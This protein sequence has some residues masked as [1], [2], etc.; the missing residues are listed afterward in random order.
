MRPAVLA[1]FVLAAFPAVAAAQNAP[2]L[3]V[4]SDHEVFLRAGPSGKFPD[5]GTVKRGLKVVVDHEE[6][7]GWLAVEAPQGQVSW[8]QMQFVEGFDVNRKPPYHI[9]VSLATDAEITLSAG[10]AGVSQ[11]LEIRRVKVPNGTPLTLIGPPVKFNGRT[12]FPVEPPPGDYRYLP[13]T[14]VQAGEPVNTAFVV[15]DTA[16]PGLTPA[17]GPSTTPGLTAGAR[18]D[19]PPAKPVV[20]YPLWA[21]AEAAERAGRPEDAEK[22]YF[23]LARVMNEPGGDH[24]IANL[25]YTRIHNLREKKRAAAAGTGTTGLLTGTRTAPARQDIGTAARPGASR[26]GR[27][28]LLPPVRNEPTGGLPPAA[29]GDERPGWTGAGMLVR[30]PVVIEGW[31]TYVLESAPGVPKV[32]AVAGPGLDLKDYVNR[33]V[34]LYGVAHTHRNVSKPYVVVTQ[35]QPNP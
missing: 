10:Q 7:N 18:P 31:Q 28:T 25:C 15:R 29:S 19:A 24:D 4:V 2:Y 22:L 26:D 13:K 6:P 35:V 9:N 33:R 14:A 34:D 16:P 12:W 5:T 1:G 20:N 8:V 11:P 23:Q 32:Y 21:Q 27:P 3:A 17:G 30:T